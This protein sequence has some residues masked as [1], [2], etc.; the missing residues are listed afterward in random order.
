MR[1][2]TLP[3]LAVGL[4]GG[5]AAPAGA[6]APPVKHVQVGDF[7]IKPGRLTVTRGTKVTWRWVGGYH[8]VTVTRGPVKFHSASK[9]SGTYSHLFLRRGTYHLECTI[10]SWMT[11]TVVVK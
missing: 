3:L 2:R 5:L 10:H 1:K 6:A 8:N 4:L 7:F 11:E 9:A